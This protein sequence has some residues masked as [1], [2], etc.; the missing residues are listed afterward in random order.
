MLDGSQW[1][2]KW[3]VNALLCDWKFQRKILHLKSSSHSSPSP[4]SPAFSCELFLDTHHWHMWTSLS[5]RTSHVAALLQH[6]HTQ[7][8]THTH[9]WWW[10]H[11]F[12]HNASLAD[13]GSVNGKFKSIRCLFST[14]F[15]LIHEYKAYLHIWIVTIQSWLTSYILN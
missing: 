1:T 7:T 8:P 11:H 14:E 3:G 4:I 6:A 12:L 9:I 10:T 2:K 5:G 13:E 15:E